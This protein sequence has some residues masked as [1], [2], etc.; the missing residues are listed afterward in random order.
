MPLGI[1]KKVLALKDEEDAD[2]AIVS[3]LSGRSEDELLHIPLPEYLALKDGSGFIFYT[4]EG[5]P[6]RDSYRIGGKVYK[7]TPIRKLITAQYID[8]KEW[9][10]VSD[11]DITAEVLAAFLVP[12]GKE[13][14]EDYDYEDAVADMEQMPTTDAAGLRGFY[15]RELARLTVGSPAFSRRMTRE[16]PIRERVQLRKLR[17]SLR[18]MLSGD[19]FA[20]LTR[21]QS[22]PAARGMQFTR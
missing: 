8:I 9:L 10:K 19:G 3:L 21:W 22:L 15:F 2:L 20:M 7:P 18:S 12:E 13:Y 5:A 11:R 6:V 4:P 17:R 14:L 1:Y 16:L